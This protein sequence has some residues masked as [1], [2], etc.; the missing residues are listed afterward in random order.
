[1]SARTALSL[2]SQYRATVGPGY[3]QGKIFAR[4]GGYR[5]TVGGNDPGGAA[6]TTPD[7]VVPGDHLAPEERDPEAPPE[8]AV[9]QATPAD[10][11][12]EQVSVHRG[13]EVSEYDAAESARIV[14]L[15]DE[16]R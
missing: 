12:H 9:E 1:M 16:Y 5:R 11:A 7:D 6:M 10:P 2:D 8:D 15:D 3:R 13:L 14:E 4:G